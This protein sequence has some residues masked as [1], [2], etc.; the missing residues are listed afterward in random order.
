MEESQDGL[1]SLLNRLE[2]VGLKVGLHIHKDKTEFMVVERRDTIIL[3]PS[4]NIKN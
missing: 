4:L 1:K 3:Y 2:K